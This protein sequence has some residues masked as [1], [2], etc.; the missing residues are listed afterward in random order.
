MG[1]TEG[2]A[3]HGC[4]LQ[5]GWWCSHWPFWTHG[6]HRAISLR[7]Q[8]A[9]QGC[10]CTS[11]SMSPSS[12]EHPDNQVKLCSLPWDAV[13][14]QEPAQGDAVPAVP[15]S[16]GCLRSRAPLLP[17]PARSDEPQV[18][19]SSGPAPFLPDAPGPG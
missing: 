4:V 9:A 15:Y 17:L 7:Q 12:G 6:L 1:E 13:W 2:R 11:S 18:T 14:Y 16:W 8:R 3:M 19:G 5:R 10:S